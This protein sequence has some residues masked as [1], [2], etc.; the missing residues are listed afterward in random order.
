MKIGFYDIEVAPN[1]W[2]ICIKLNGEWIKFENFEG[3]FTRSDWEKLKELFNSN[4][5]W[6]G[7]NNLRYD[8]QIIEHLLRG[9]VSNQS[10]FRLSKYIIISNKRFYDQISSRQIDPF[11][12]WGFNNKMKRVSLK[13]LGFVLRRPKMQSLPFDPEKP[14]TRQV[15]DDAWDY[16][17]KDVE[18]AEYFGRL[19]IEKIK[20][21]FQNVNILGRKVINFSDNQIGQESF[22]KVMAD[23]TNTNIDRLRYR[24]TERDVI[25]FKDVI[26]P[27]YRFTNPSFRK[28][29]AW[30]NDQVVY[31]QDG[32]IKLDNKAAQIVRFRDVTVKY[33]YGGVHGV[34]PKGWYHSSSNMVIIS[35]DVTSQY[36]KVG[37]ANRFHP[38]HWPQDIFCD[39]YESRFIER[40]QYAKGTIENLSRK[41]ELNCVYG[42]SNNYYSP[43]YDPLYT[44]AIT[45]NGQL[46]VTWLMNMIIDQIPGCY[47]IMMNTDGIEVAVPA[48]RVQQYMDICKEWEEKTGLNLEHDKY[49]FMFINNVNNYLAQYESGKIKRKGGMFR[50]YEDIIGDSEFHKNPSARVISNAISKYVTE[51]IP[52]EEYIPTETNIHEFLYG[53]RVSTRGSKKAQFCYFYPKDRVVKFKREKETVIRF[54]MAKNGK[55]LFKLFENGSITAINKEGIVYPLMDI[56]THK[57]TM[58]RNFNNIDMQWYIDQSYKICNPIMQ[59]QIV[60][61]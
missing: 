4:I 13:Q 17:Q 6:L 31:A 12:I 28:A 55:S 39:T 40:Q 56:P 7:Y 61:E 36:P 45:V 26:L 15:A 52:P 44:V 21:R 8:A 47:P 33:G 50:T 38:A 9:K 58:T 48:G 42:N 41:L 46:C 10:V 49:K 2:M 29:L 51:S 14:V 30:F 32:I 34:V 5:Y 18:D 60:L 25:R 16:A 57:G 37:I 3:S 59:N 35:S 1:W 27:Y 23:K 22:L 19:S 24:K 43:F 53:A 11:L 20:Y 54:Y